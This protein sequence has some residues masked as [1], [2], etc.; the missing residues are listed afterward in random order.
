MN[1]IKLVLVAFVVI[2]PAAVLAKPLELIYSEK[3]IQE[4]TDKDKKFTKEEKLS[5]RVVKLFPKQFSIQTERQETI[6]DFVS[7]TITIVDLHNNSYS[8]VPLYWDISYRSTEKKNRVNMGKM[9]QA[10]N[11]DAS[12]MGQFELE[13]LFSL[14]GEQP[15]T[16]AIEASTHKDTVTFTYKG[17][18]VTSFTADSH[19]IPDDIKP[20]YKKYLLYS[21]AIHPEIRQKLSEKNTLFKTLSFRTKPFP[22]STD[23]KTYTLASVKEINDTDIALPQ[24]AKEVFLDK[25]LDKVLAASRDTSKRKSEDYYVK[26]IDRLFKDKNHLDAFLALNEY[27]FQ[28]NVQPIDQMK[29]IFSDAPEK[30]PARMLVGALGAKTKEQYQQ[31]IKIMESLPREKLEHGYVIDIFTANDYSRLGNFNKAIELMLSA[32]EKNP[33]M[34][35]PYKDLGDFYFAKFEINT[36]WQIWGNAQELNPGHSQ[37]QPILK[38]ENVLETKYPEFF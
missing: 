1:F 9:M 35:G 4:R 10:A 27:M 17:E 24:G 20:I 29:Q 19:T 28:Y 3:F 31:A 5:K 8:K 18:E 6:Y 30:S 34:I 14:A 7:K 16:P 12:G 2:L 25:T 23:T 22:G 38:Y 37:L 21:Y 15:I 13:A 33:F 32:L 26:E 36:A 11:I